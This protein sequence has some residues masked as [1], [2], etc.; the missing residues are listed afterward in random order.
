[1]RRPVSS[2]GT[3]RNSLIEKSM[4]WSPSYGDTASTVPLFD[5]FM[6]RILPGD[7]WRTAAP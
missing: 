3:I 4:I 5:E 6:K 2:S 1:M 7:A